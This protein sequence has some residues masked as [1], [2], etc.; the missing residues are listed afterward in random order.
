[1]MH[2]GACSTPRRS[3]RR[4]AVAVIALL[5]A[6]PLDAGVRFGDA[7]PAIVRAPDLE[8]LKDRL[9]LTRFSV[10]AA[11]RLGA[12]D[13]RELVIAEPLSEEALEHVEKSCEANRFCPAPYGF[14]ASRVRIVHLRD[15]DVGTILTVDSEARDAQGRIFAPASFDVPGRLIGW[16]GYAEAAAGHVVLVLTPIVRIDDDLVSAGDPVPFTLMWD[17]EMERF[18]LWEC[19]I[20]DDGIERCAFYREEPE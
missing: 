12:L 14:V 11:I 6:T 16:N 3:G 18:A 13:G 4:I 2:R 5:A 20:E 17:E 7:V 8:V 1:M 15:R 9:N 19:S 10:I